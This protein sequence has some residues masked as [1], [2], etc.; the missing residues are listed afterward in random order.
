MKFRRGNRKGGP[1]GR[2]KA[3]G[4]VKA[5]ETTNQ[6]EGNLL[7]GK[8]REGDT[9]SVKGKKKKIESSERAVGVMREEGGDCPRAEEI[10]V[11]G[12]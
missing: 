4:G 11:G 9:L 2:R 1:T 7:Q 6:K 10:K 3:A 8:K 5:Y 12:K